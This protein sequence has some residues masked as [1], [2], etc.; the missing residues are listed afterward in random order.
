[1]GKQRKKYEREFKLEAIRLS[2]DTRSTARAVERELGLYQGAISHWKQ[3]FSKEGTD[4]FPGNG[5][6]SA[7]QSKIQTLKIKL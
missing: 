7:E 1:M 5:K 3:E 2:E 4:A 6:Q